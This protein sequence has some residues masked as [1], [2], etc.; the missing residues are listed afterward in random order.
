MKSAIE[1]RKFAVEKAVEIMGAGTADKDVVTKA[2]EIEAYVLGGAILPETYDESNALSG[3][4]G[5]ILANIPLET[6]TKT[7]K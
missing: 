6:G 4:I 2:R 5:N 1:V 7:K 3:A